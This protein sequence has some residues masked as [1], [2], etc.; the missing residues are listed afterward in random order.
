MIG[1]APRP[2]G[3]GTGLNEVLLLQAAEMAPHGLHRD[4]EGIS[5]L[6]GRGFSLSQQEGQHGITR[7]KGLGFC[8]NPTS[9]SRPISGLRSA[10]KRLQRV[11]DTHKDRGC[12]FSHTTAPSRCHGHGEIGDSHKHTCQ[13]HDTMGPAEG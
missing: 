4:V 12:G 13:R 9:I 10:G 2:S 7:G 1:G 6:S 5:E 11:A 8:R 3:G